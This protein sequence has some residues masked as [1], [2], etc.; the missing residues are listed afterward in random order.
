MEKTIPTY[1]T[2]TKLV[3]IYYIRDYIIATLYMGLF[4]KR[5]TCIVIMRIWMHVLY[6][7]SDSFNILG[8]CVS[9]EYNQ[10]IAATAILFCLVYV[11]II[12]RFKITQQP[13]RLMAPSYTQVN[14][15]WGL[16]PKGVC[17]LCFFLCSFNWWI[18]SMLDKLCLLINIQKNTV[19]V[20]KLV[21]KIYYEYFMWKTILFSV[22]LLVL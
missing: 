20:L 7:W 22:I 9:M 11:C 10:R 18:C 12:P 15:K 4:I 17:N 1:S 21:C 3:Q 5:W 6:I 13:I 2:H 19:I 8:H 16:D 14:D